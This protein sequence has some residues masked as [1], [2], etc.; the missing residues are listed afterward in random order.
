MSA[1]EGA[2]AAP[3]DGFS[4]VLPQ[5]SARIYRD[6]Q[7]GKVIVRDVYDPNASQLVPNELY[8]VL[9]NHFEHFQ[10]LY[11]H[12]GM[13]LVFNET[14]SFFYLSEPNDEEGE[15]HDENA[16]KVQVALLVIGR[17]FARSGRDLEYLG[18]ADMGLR[19]EDLAA[20]ESD[21]QYNDLLR[22]ARFKKGFSEAVDYLE[23]RCFLFRSGARRAFLSSAGMCF[24]NTLVE[25][26]EQRQRNDV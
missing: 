8:N 22:T 7:A 10:R 17:Y 12:L 24:L 15:E 6:F 9:Y 2:T 3:S 21:E 25:G 5:H 19:E 20:L 23:K 16:F 13:E 1:F 26:Y 14:G 18:R 11:E 4:E